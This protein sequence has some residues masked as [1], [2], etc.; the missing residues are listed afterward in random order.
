M[1]QSCHLCE[2]H[3]G[4]DRSAGEQGLCHAGSDARVFW[5]QTEVTDELELLPVFAVA[6]S[7][8]DF[9]CNFCITGAPSWNARAGQAFSAEK[10]ASQARTALA[11]GARSIMILGGEPTI[12]LPAVVEFVASLP[13]ESRLIWKTNAYASAAAREVLDGLFDTWLVDYKYQYPRAPQ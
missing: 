6:L 8:C 9:R 12:H 5:T 1:L 10:V 13:D 7:G 3:C 11:Q 2:H 4:V